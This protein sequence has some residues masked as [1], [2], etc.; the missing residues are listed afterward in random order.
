MWLAFYGP[1]FRGGRSLGQAGTSCEKIIQVGAEDLRLWISILGSSSLSG[2]RALAQVLP[3]K[4]RRILAAPAN[5]LADLTLPRW[6][7]V[8]SLFPPPKTRIRLWCARFF[9]SL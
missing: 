3:P 4:E 7:I 9:G 5:I 2:G 8:A 1:F 6:Q